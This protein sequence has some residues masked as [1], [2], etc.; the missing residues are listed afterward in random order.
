MLKGETFGVFI[1]DTGSPG[2]KAVPRYL[3]PDRKSWVAVIVEPHVVPGVLEGMADCVTE[4]ARLPGVSEFHAADIYSGKGPYRQMPLEARL[5]IFEAVARVFA[6]YRIP[7]LVQTLDPATLVRVRSREALPNRLGPFDLTAHD[8]LA[9]LLLLG[10]VYNHVRE[11]R[12]SG[13]SR[14]RVFVDEGRMKSGTIIQLPWVADVLADGLVCFADSKT[15]QPLQLADFAAFCLNRSQ[16]LIGR[17]ARSDVDWRFL[18]LFEQMVQSFVNL[19]KSEVPT[20][21]NGPLFSDMP[22]VLPESDRNE[23]RGITGE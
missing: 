6:S 10:R 11:T 9:L 3:H 8:D 15:I 13:E 19:A 17:Q 14:A 16:I 2:N 23:S 4:L 21:V 5:T 18:L 7:V 12:R 22:P 1:D 20:Y